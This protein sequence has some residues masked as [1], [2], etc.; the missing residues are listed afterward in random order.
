MNSVDYDNNKIRVSL[1]RSSVH[2]PMCALQN[3]CLKNN[4]CKMIILNFHNNTVEKK[5]K[6]GLSLDKF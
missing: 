5:N 2:S 1:I 6:V 3:I 4:N